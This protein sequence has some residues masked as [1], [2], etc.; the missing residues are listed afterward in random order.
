MKNILILV[1]LVFTLA[2]CKEETSREV[3]LA[4]TP[5]GRSFYFMPIHEDGVTDI[6]ITIAWPMN[7]AHV[8]GNN[9]A[10]PYVAAEAILSGGTSEAAPQDIMELFNDKNAYGQLYARADHA[11]GELSFP[12][13]H[14][15]EIVSIASV[16]LASPQFEEAWVERIK[17]GVL[18]NQKQAQAQTENQMWAVARQAILGEGPLNDFLS[19][20]NLTDIEA[21]SVDDLRRWHQETIV[22][23]GVTIA[24][25]G[26]IN[27]QDA[28]EAVDQMLSALP[29]ASGSVTASTRPNF[30]P[31]T[32]LLHVP[33]AEKT[34][35]GF[36][37]QLPP[38]SEGGDLTDLLTLQL[39]SQPGSGPL[40][41][42]V[43]TELRASYGF[44]AGY[45]NFDRATRIMLI[46]GEVETSKLSQAIDLIRDTYASYKSSPNLDGFDDLR[47]AIAD[48]TRQNI[49]YVDIAAR[50]MLELALDARD[51][52][53]TP[54]LGDL[55]TAI[56][57]DEVQRRLASVFPSGDALIVIAASPDADALPGACVITEVSQVAQCP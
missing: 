20:P 42:A 57:T 1:A 11:I 24:V 21:V 38:T 12:K 22:Q 19:L 25:T 39:F 56:T 48:G 15:N 49:L 7:W 10:V 50:T 17:Q 30:E 36:I 18:A 4:E 44:Q 31:K 54:R 40:F 33:D 55:V 9:P 3:V 26:A 27:Q 51:P 52:S 8:S 16:M 29:D 46:A 43:R 32:I 41:D 2:S 47:R 5:D 34:T 35:L 6:T 14:I 53:D 13:E 45:T 23:G 28:G 37:G